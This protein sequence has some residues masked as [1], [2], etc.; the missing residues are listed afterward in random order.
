MNVLIILGSI[1]PNDDANTNIAK[2]IAEQM[3]IGGH[4]VCMLGT[5]FQACPT[6]E[7]IDGV[8]YYRILRL[9]S[10]Q[11]KRLA[12]EWKGA[13]SKKEKINFVFKHPV[14]FAKLVF[15]HLQ[16]KVWDTAELQ[17]IR[18]IKNITQKE[19]L[20]RIIVITSPFYV[21]RAAAK[22]VRDIELV[23]Y[24]LDPN[25]SNTTL[26]YK[27]IKNLLEEEKALYERVKFAVIPKLVYE[28]NQQGQLATYISKMKAADFPNVRQLKRYSPTDEVVFDSEKINIVFVGTFYEDIRSPESLFELVKRI[29]DERFVFHVIGGGCVEQL[30]ECAKKQ[31]GKFIYHGYR[32]LEASINAMQNASVLVN[33]DNTAKNMLPS[34]IND[35]I[36]A[37]RPIVNLYPHQDSDSVKY[38]N[39]YGLCLNVYTGEGI[40]DEKIEQ[41]EYFCLDNYAKSEDFDSI[42]TNYKTSTP[43]F[44]TKLLLSEM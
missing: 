1:S 42:Q 36:S 19:K 34:K 43:D 24:Q 3:K 14:Y 7:W 20:D 11:E 29:K 9:E 35:Y 15:R 12:L 37:C 23:W 39:G 32:S 5:A 8:K 6:E 22:A 4:S 18:E 16:A 21:A 30:E 31:K 2:L 40:T 28:E 38:L 41:I 27:D 13:N 33:V 17:Y 26:A 44:V 25:Y 10:P